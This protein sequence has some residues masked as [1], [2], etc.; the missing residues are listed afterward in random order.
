[1]A[2]RGRAVVTGLYILD[3]WTLPLT[4]C[5]GIT[6]GWHH[7]ADEMRLGTLPAHCHAPT[8]RADL[9]RPRELWKPERPHPNLCKES[10]TRRGGGAPRET[11]GRRVMKGRRGGDCEPRRHRSRRS[12][13]TSFEPPR[14]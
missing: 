6:E 3:Q 8:R 2:S 14:P 11:R 9:D 10:R 7:H 12:L 4:I 13:V 1:M 5:T